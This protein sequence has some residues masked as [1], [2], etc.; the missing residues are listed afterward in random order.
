MSKQ[1]PAGGSTEDQDGPENSEDSQDADAQSEQTDETDEN[2][3]ANGGG[4]GEEGGDADQNGGESEGAEGDEGQPDPVVEKVLAALAPTLEKLVP[5]KEED[6]GGEN[7]VKSLLLPLP[8]E[9]QMAALKE[10][11]TADPAQA[12]PLVVNLINRAITGLF[13]QIEGLR[14][15]GS[16]DTAI[17]SLAADKSGKFRDAAKFRSEIRQRMSK[18]AAKDR[19]NK[20]LLE[21]AYYAA[22]GSKAGQIV[23]KKEQGTEVNRRI[24]QRTRVASPGAAGK[25]GKGQQSLTPA[26]KEAYMAGKKAGLFK[27]EKEYADYMKKNPKL[28]VA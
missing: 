12:V 18:F 27:T 28:R 26:Q 7:D 25:G 6:G 21:M 20:D 10:K 13:G 15:D 22:V 9:Q 19:T 1:S 4:D 16:L 3:G 17:D 5:K 2:D 24:A 23:R 11:L 14:A 8:N